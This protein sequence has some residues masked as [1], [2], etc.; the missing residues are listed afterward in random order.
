MSIS[1]LVKRGS[2][3]AGAAAVSLVT[4]ASAAQADYRGHRGH[5]HGWRD[6][7]YAERYDAPRYRHYH[8]DQDQRRRDRDKRVARGVAIGVGAV[9]LGTILAAEANR[10]HS[11]GYDD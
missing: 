1:D 5:D 6:R 9:I 7:G 4:V 2:L 8:D 11:H 10:R 3:I